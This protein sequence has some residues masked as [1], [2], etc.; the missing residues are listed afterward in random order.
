MDQPGQMEQNAAQTGPARLVSRE[1]MIYY[2]NCAMVATTPRD[3]AVYFGR[4]TPV[5]D[6]K[7]GQQL[8][9][10]YERQIYMTFEQAEDLVRILSQTLQAVKSKKAEQTNVTAPMQPSVKAPIK[11]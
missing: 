9:E 4:F 10:L 1:V 11:K 6:E 5:S 3:L 8:A 2:A 7:G